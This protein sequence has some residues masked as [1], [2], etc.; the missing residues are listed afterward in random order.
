[1]SSYC[2]LSSQAWFILPANY[3]DTIEERS[4]AKL[5]GYPL[6]SNKLGKVRAFYISSIYV[7]HVIVFLMH[8]V[9]ILTVIRLILQIPTQKYKIS[10]KTNKVYDITERKVSSATY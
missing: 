1:M 7:M 5:C 3:K 2:V 8:D 10:T 6:C 4:I 9:F